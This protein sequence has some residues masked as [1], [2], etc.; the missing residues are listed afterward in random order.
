MSTS[1]RTRLRLPSAPTKYAPRTRRRSPSAPATTAVT[2]RPV[3]LDNDQRPTPPGR[4]RRAAGDRLAQRLLQPVLRAP[5]RGARRGRRAGRPT[6]ANTPSKR[7]MVCPVRLVQN[8][9]E[10]VPT[11]REARVVPD[12][13]GNAQPSVGLHRLRIDLF[14]SAA[15]RG[16]RAAGSTTT[17]STSRDPSSCRE[18]QADRTRP[19]DDHLGLE[20]PVGQCHR[21]SP[22][23][24]AGIH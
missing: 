1:P 9:A 19:S 7:S 13:L 11:E 2:P 20:V 5:Q 8:T 6:G 3:L 17:Q 14:C 12:R 24:R 15:K 10:S 4:D 21:A 16:R 23:A 18:R 22:E